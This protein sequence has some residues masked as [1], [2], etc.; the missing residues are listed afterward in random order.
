MSLAKFLKISDSKQVGKRIFLLALPFILAFAAI[1]CF[2]FCGGTWVKSSIENSSLAALFNAP[3]LKDHEETEVQQITFDEN[4]IPLEQF[5]VLR[6]GDKWATMAVDELPDAKIN[7]APVYVGDTPD[8]LKKGVGKYFGSRFCGEGGK[9]VLDA[10]C[11]KE[12][13][14]LEDMKIGYTVR[15]HTVYGEYV[16]RVDNIIFFTNQDE[17]VVLDETD[18]EQLLLYTCYPRGITYRRQRI[19]IVCSK[20]SGADFR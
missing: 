16:Y 14:C 7:G 13:Y 11:N 2:A 1:A 3:E 18:E 5:P 19:G 4:V 6:W 12:F 9:I 20:V 10:H 15:M 17:H 8:L